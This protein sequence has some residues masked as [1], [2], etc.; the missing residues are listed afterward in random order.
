[1]RAARPG[2]ARLVPRARWGPGPSGRGL[3][4]SAPSQSLG[5][6][7]W[8]L[9]AP[10]RVRA[11]VGPRCGAH[12][13]CER[14]GRWVPGPQ[15][16]LA[17]RVPV[18]VG[19]VSWRGGEVPASLL[20]GGAW[21]A[22]GP[23][24][25]ASVCR[26]GGSHQQ[27]WQSDAVQGCNN[28]KVVVCSRFCLDRGGEGGEMALPVVRPIFEVELLVG[29]DRRN[30]RKNH[31][32]AVGNTVHSEVGA[33]VEPIIDPTSPAGADGRVGIDIDGGLAGAC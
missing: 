24:R 13:Q 8:G 17:V 10:R 6:A 32:F 22:L 11:Q 12:P 26:C 4:W 23:G 16:G 27:H 25:R 9:H 30:G 7:G 2:V 19:A 5:S 15:E 3:A 18:G 1:M 28:S 31:P 14:C 20:D 29:V 33:S 21:A